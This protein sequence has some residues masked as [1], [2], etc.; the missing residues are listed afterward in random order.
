M[1]TNCFVYIPT[2]DVIYVCVC[3]FVCLCVW[4]AY[5]NDPANTRGGA[6][7]MA[8]LI[9]LLNSAW[10]CPPWMPADV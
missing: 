1:L 4:Q 7:A 3:V 10:L 2:R 5:L 9:L 8:K 6:E